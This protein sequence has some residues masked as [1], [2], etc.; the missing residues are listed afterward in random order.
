MKSFLEQHLRG[1]VPM[2]LSWLMGSVMEAKG[3]QELFEHQRPEVLETLRQTAIIQSVESSNRIEGVTVARNRL[4]PL[5][6]GSTAPRD[7]SEAEIVG[8]RQALAWIHQEHIA[9]AINQDNIRQVHRL[10]QSVSGD[11]GQYKAVQ[12]HIIELFPD[13][14]RAVRFET[15]AVGEVPD[16]MEQLCLAWEHVTAQR[17]LPGLLAT[18]SFVLDFLCIHPFRDGNGRAARLLTL[19]LLYHCGYRVGRYISLERLIEQSKESYYEALHASSQ[20][21]HQGKHDLTPWWSYFLSIIRQ[22]Y[23]EFEAGVE[24]LSQ[25]QGAKAGV[26]KNAV[27]S[28]PSQFRLADIKA[29]CPSVSPE[30]IRKVLNQIRENGEL[31][32]RGRG[33]GARWHKIGHGGDA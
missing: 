14:R 20:G 7:R 30:Y 8:Y 33:R 29:L 13:G 24:D 4:S 16:M 19:L 1:S 11:A 31:E 32:L 22:A 17:Q 25:S 12:N 26:V 5:V 15:V 2:G 23:K 10:C 28:L 18:A 9:L 27:G 3:R 6:Q 21:W